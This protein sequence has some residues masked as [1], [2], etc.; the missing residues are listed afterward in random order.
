M[1]IKL[2]KEE[3]EMLELLKKETK[4]GEIT[5]YFLKYE[6]YFITSRT[7]N[8]L[9]LKGLLN[10]NLREQGKDANK[11]YIKIKGLKISNFKIISKNSKVV[12][13]LTSNK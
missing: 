13:S 8:R 10:Y 3:Y 7:I 1:E 5:L 9:K 6:N 12:I 2:P 11:Y 4:D